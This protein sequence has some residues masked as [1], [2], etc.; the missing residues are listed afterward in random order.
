MGSDFAIFES[1][2]QPLSG[3]FYHPDYTLPQANMPKP[4][5]DEV[6][7]EENIAKAAEPSKEHE[8]DTQV[9]DSSN[10]AVASADECQN[11]KRAL[12]LFICII[13]GFPPST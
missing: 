5:G 2:A 1:R 9:E 12:H 8:G 7:N 13:Y 11:G 3:V 4:T 10:A 6:P